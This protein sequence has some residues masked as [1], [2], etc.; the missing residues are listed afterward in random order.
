MTNREF[1]GERL[2]IDL[3]QYGGVTAYSTDNV[4]MLTAVFRE[5]MLSGVEAV[6]F[7]HICT[8]YNNGSKGYKPVVVTYKE[9]SNLIRVAEIS[10]RKCL[11][12]LISDGLLLRVRN[13]DAGAKYGYAPNVRLIQDLILKFNGLTRNTLKTDTSVSKN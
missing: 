2:Y 3:A 6:I 12:R 9:L 1:K 8:E 5:Y 13:V 10:I 7:L 4:G 11:K